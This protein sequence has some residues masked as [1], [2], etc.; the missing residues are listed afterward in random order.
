MTTAVSFREALRD[1]L[2]ADMGVAA[3]IGENAVHPSVLPEANQRK[4]PAIVYSVITDTQ[5]LSH[6]GPVP[7]RNPL[8]QVDVWAGQRLDA[9]LVAEAVIRAMVGYHGAMGDLA[10]TTAWRL[11]DSTDLYEQDTKLHRISLEFRG[12]YAP[13]EGGAS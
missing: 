1:F 7:L 3:H 12:W 13:E 10:Y 5:M 2:L 6:D 11:D 8:V 9:E 4:L